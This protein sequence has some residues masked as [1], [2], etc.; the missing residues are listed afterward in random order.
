MARGKAGAGARAKGIRNKQKRVATFAKFAKQG[1]KEQKKERKKRQKEAEELGEEAAPRK[2]QRTLD[3]TREPDET[4]VQPD[5]AEVAAEDSFDEFAAHFSGSVP[6][7]TVVTTSPKPSS[8]MLTFLEEMVTLLPNAEYRKRGAHELKAIVGAAAERGFTNLL[9]FSEKNKKC[10]TLW[11][12]KLPAGPT[13]RY[14]VSSV[15]LPAK[16]RGHGRPTGHRPEL[17]LNNFST[18]LGHRLGRMLACLFPYD[19][20]FKGR[21]AVTLHNQRDFVF[22]RHHRYVFE[23]RRQGGD[24]GARL[25]EL[26]PR[27]TLKLKGLQLGTFDT[28]HGEYEWKHKPELDT[29]RRR[30]HI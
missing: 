21:Q 15:V 28:Q 8:E 29:S 17:I 27:V 24:V 19:P 25:Q 9:V 10:H 13:A 20:Q 3:N 22:L 12:V 23:Q 18:R 5:D 2:A 30:F 11:H 26:G 6:P 4:V 1:E 16:I 14:K 7:R